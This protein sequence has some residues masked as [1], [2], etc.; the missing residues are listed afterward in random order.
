MKAYIFIAGSL[1][2]LLC[3]LQAVAQYTTFGDSVLANFTKE[4]NE[5][6]SQVQ[7][8]A[9][10]AADPKFSKE[11]NNQKTGHSG[12]V[13]VI[14]TSEMNGSPC[15]VLRVQNQA[16]GQVGR[17][18]HLWCKMSDGSWKLPVAQPQ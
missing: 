10:N 1:F 4:D 17:Q 14:S 2:L 8:E 13:S 16:D 11:W 15:R 3:P 9:L 12:S 7:K 18:E 5:M 6:A